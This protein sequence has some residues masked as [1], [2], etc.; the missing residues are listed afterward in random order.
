MKLC[1]GKRLSAMTEDVKVSL[2][3]EGSPV[4]AQG[5]N[6]EVLCHTANHAP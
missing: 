2:M 3:S 6:P 4:T 5:P 1:T